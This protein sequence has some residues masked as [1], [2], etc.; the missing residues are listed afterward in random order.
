M[1]RYE[2]PNCLEIWKLQDLNPIQDIFERVEADESMPAG[3]CP[4]D[5]CCGAL[6]HE[7]ANEGCLEGME[8][9]KCGEIEPF[10]IECKICRIVFDD[11]STESDRINDDTLWN[12]DSFCE[13]TECGHSGTV[14]D[15]QKKEPSTPEQVAAR[16]KKIEQI[17]EIRSDNFDLR[18]YLKAWH[19]E[20][21]QELGQLSD[22]ELDKVFT[23]EIG[24]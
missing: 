5:E 11:G 9:P 1:A 22:V 7:I 4:G 16:A 2:C 19:A 20:Q 21:V 8:C 23:E 24:E 15:F 17:A 13:C 14:K 3:E 10:K 6:C 18:D 12:D